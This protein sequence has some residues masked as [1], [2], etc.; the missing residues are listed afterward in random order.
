MS[1]FPEGYPP[2]LMVRILSNGGD[3]TAYYAFR[4]GKYGLMDPR[5]F[6]NTH[7]E[8][9]MLGTRP[10]LPPGRKAKK[11]SLS[12]YSTSCFMTIERPREICDHSMREHPQ[13]V[14]LEGVT[15]PACGPTRCNEFTGH[16]DWWLYKDSQPHMFFS[17]IEVNSNEG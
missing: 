9:R 16:V 11:P 17:E 5:S 3:F 13:A 2:D 8:K 10:K 7:L 4:V 15:C 1:E 12:D 14:I 6:W